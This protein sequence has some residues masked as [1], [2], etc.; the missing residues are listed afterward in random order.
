MSNTLGCDTAT[1]INQ[2]QIQTLLSG[3]YTFVGRYLR[4]LSKEEAKL[5]TGSGICIVSLY[6]VNPTHREYFT[7][8]RGR[9]DAADAIQNA[10]RVGQTHHK[11]IYFTVDYDA[12]DDD[13]KGCISA[14]LQAVKDEFDKDG[15]RYALGLYGSGAV[16]THF[17]DTY[18]YT[19]L[20]GASGWRGSK[21]YTGWSIRQ[22]ANGSTIG[23]GSGSILIDKDESKGSGGGWL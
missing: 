10:D 12:S 13:V 16:L 20:A 3:G 19:W 17:Q 11:P 4:H 5:I 22:Y 14:Y 9:T 6:E 1:T 18:T 8:A 21:G 2:D 7:A 23:S 15:N